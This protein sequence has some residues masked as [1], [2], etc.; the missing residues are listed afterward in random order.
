MNPNRCSKNPKW[1]YYLNAV[2]RYFLTLLHK[3]QLHSLDAILNK[4]QDAEYI[5]RRTNYYNKLSK[6]FELP[7]DA[8]LLADNTFKNKLGN[9]VYFFD[10][11]E[12]LRYFPDNLR[13][14]HIPGDVTVV[15]NYP[16][17]VKSRPI[18]EDN[19]NSVLLNLN[20]V[21]HFVFVED[22]LPYLQKSDMAIFRGKVSGKPKRKEFFNLYFGNPLCDLGD[23]SHGGDTPKEWKT[24]KMS[25]PKQLKY[26]FILSIEGNDVASN[27]KWIMSSNSIAVMPKPEFETWFM[28]G[29]LLPDYH[30]IE[31]KKDFSDLEEKLQYYLKNENLAFE[32]IRNAN[33][34]VSQ[35]LDAKR[36]KLISLMVLDKYFKLER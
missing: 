34:Y 5:L 28:E 12:Y 32:I 31:I 25:I 17:I 27:L 19:A 21:R 33:E 26:K 23:T 29:E 10:T 36:E 16:T 18:A 1:S 7:E 14:L 20:K 6:S 9:S 15:P 3:P 8:P 4:R 35:F 24:S 13:W 2:A 11:H 30:Y 22:N